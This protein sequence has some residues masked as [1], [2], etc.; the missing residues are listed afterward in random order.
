MRRAVDGDLTF[1]ILIPVDPSSKRIAV[2][3]G[4]LSELSFSYVLGDFYSHFRTSVR[5]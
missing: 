4:K 5:R 1:I 3:L 2:S